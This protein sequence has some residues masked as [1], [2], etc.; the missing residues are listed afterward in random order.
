MIQR[1]HLF[2]TWTIGSHLFISSFEPKK[3]F[4]GKPQHLTF[5][6]HGLVQRR[7]HHGQ[8]LAEKVEATSDD[9][10]CSGEEQQAAKMEAGDLSKV[11]VLPDVGRAEQDEVF[12]V[13][14]RF[15]DHLLAAL[16]RQ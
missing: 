3:P 9:Q 14:L 10:R 2:V 6:E 1:V 5:C 4:L 12:V 15:E 16:Q 13:A 7:A 8:Q 11:A